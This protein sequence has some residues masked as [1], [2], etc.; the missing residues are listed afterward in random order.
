DLSCVSSSNFVINV[1][2]NAPAAPLA[3]LTQPTCL[4]PTGT[5]VVTSPLGVTLEYSKDG[6]NWQSSTTFGSL[7]PGFTYT[8]RV[9]D[10]AGDLSC[11][12][13]ADFVINPVPF[14]PA[15]PLAILTQPTCLLPTGTIVVTS[16][17]GATLEYSKDGI[18]WQSST[19]FGSLAP[20]FTYTIRVR[21]SAGDQNCIS[22]ASFLINPIPP[23]P[24]AI[25][26]VVSNVSCYG[27]NDGSAIV[28]VSGGAGNYNY[29][30]STNPIQ[31]T[32][33][34]TGL[35]SGT[36]TVT[37]TDT[38]GCETTAEASIT[39]PVE[40]FVDAGDDQGLCQQNITVL[41][42]NWP[43]SGSTGNWT[44][45]SQ[46]PGTP[47][48][49][50]FPVNS[51]IATV[52]GLQPSETIPYVFRYTITTA[53]PGGVICTV[54]D[55]MEVV[56]Q[57]YPSLPN[58]GQNQKLCLDTLAPYINLAA[59]N[60][61]Y[62][63]GIWSQA[64]GPLAT[65]A[66]IHNP[67]T[68]V[69]YTSVGAYTFLWTVNNGYCV[70]NEPNQDA[71]VIRIDT[72]PYVYACPDMEICSG[73]T[74]TL[75][76]AASSSNCMIFVWSTNG[77]GAFN[78][79]NILNPVYTPSAIDIATGSVTLIIV[80]YLGPCS[81]CGPAILSDTMVL[82]I[83]P[84]PIPVVSVVSNAGCYGYSDGS[85]TVAVTSGALP[86]TFLWSDGQTT[87][88]ATGLIA[89]TYYVTV[90]DH[91]GCAGTDTG[92]VV[93]PSPIFLQAVPVD[94]IC[95]GYS[96]GSINLTVTGGTPSYNFL[97]S[98][99][100]TTEDIS[101]LATGTYTVTVTDSKS[102][103][104]N[105]SWVINGP[106]EWSIGIVGDTMVCCKTNTPSELYTYNATIGG[107]YGSPVTYEWVVEGGVIVSGQNS[108][109][110]T[111]RWSCCETG[112]V[113]L[114]VSQGP[115][116]CLLTTF[117][118]VTITPT[119]A[120][121]ITGEPQVISG[122]TNSQYCTTFVPGRLYSWSVVG[123]SVTSGQGTNCITITWGPYPACG[124]G[125]VTIAETYNGC[126]GTDLFYVTILPGENVSVNGYV[127]YDNDYATRMNGVTI[128]LRNSSGGIVGTT[129]TINNPV[130][131][132]PG[133]YAFTDL[134][135]GAYSINGSHN[136]VW[137]GNNATDAL[138]VQLNVI[139]LYPLLSLRDSVADVN[140]SM[141]ISALDALYIKLRT[142]GAIASFPAGD[143]KITDTTVN[144]SVSELSVDIKALCVGDVNGSYIPQGLKETSN[145]SIVADGLMSIKV[146][147][148]FTYNIY[149]GNDTDFGAMTLFLGFDEQRFEVIDVTSA[150]AEMKYS[151]LDGNISI[152]WADAKSLKLNHKNPVLMFTLKSKENVGEPSQIF[153]VK[154]GSEFADKLALPFG[155]FELKMPDIVT[156]GSSEEIGLSNYPNPFKNST[157]IVYTLP[158]SGGVK[159]VLTN[160]Y[161]TFV[162]SLVMENKNA[163]SY[164]V[165]IDPDELNLIPGIY[166][167]KI[168]F[169]STNGT[170]VKVSKM[171]LTR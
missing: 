105:A 111:V 25:A 1:V 91:N 50:I 140:G 10:S 145:V 15:A 106:G 52:V 31:I 129:H 82:T 98:N 56:D 155:N 161:G 37:V 9:R 19:T 83:N 74:I 115:I 108:Q 114:T 130:T 49:T 64:S 113:W 85:L 4:L 102:C 162:R 46:P 127:F 117:I 103:A 2:P 73:S 60:P 159:L 137:G 132:L 147:E 55:E 133:Y 168:I 131:G 164:M 39:Q 65:I 21:D 118:D 12:S 81:P 136:G 11:I 142:V 16:P 156:S 121:V 78:N 154:A 112:K 77:T 18:N 36:Y 94:V 8:I 160:L 152:A 97:W 35:S 68:Q 5:I 86:Y 171:V 101:G 84:G 104:A 167:Y 92:T 54:Y 87:E 24:T 3:N 165:K 122:Q 47:V 75:T 79:Q 17:L 72:L 93:Q 62:G 146:N 69:T 63:T 14:P 67:N 26:A 41:A 128:Q 151:L 163:G 6:I 96:E 27:G 99:G 158:V 59:N 7:A 44:V 30:W 61:L 28:A 13:S 42:G 40:V 126:T 139:G 88:T 169:Q 110:L 32:A 170:V 76:C 80:G 29:L 53:Y 43:S 51:P 124:C 135:N 70:P 100:N 125:T 71:V 34:A 66:D 150:L 57:H 120:P 33:I 90:T 107:T 89:G 166:F 143:W 116:P 109:M 23:N 20:G 149:S 157:T 38:N 58:A 22:D 119:P 153:T 148:P 95:Y 134:A 48:L 45:I 138:I 144:Y 123:G 141:T